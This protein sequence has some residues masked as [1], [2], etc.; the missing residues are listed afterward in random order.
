MVLLD[1]ESRENAKYFYELG[2]DAAKNLESD[3]SVKI[4]LNLIY[5]EFM[6]KVIKQT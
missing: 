5:Y 2:I 4:G 1:T 6:N 3:N